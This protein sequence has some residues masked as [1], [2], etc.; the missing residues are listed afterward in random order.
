MKNTVKTKKL[1]YKMVKPSK[2]LNKVLR[3]FQRKTN[4]KPKSSPAICPAIGYGI[5]TNIYANEADDDDMEYNKHAIAVAAATAAVAEAAL[6]AANAAAE[7]VRLTNNAP[8]LVS[9]RRFYLDDFAAVKIQSAFRGYLARRALRALKGLV[10]LQALV[11]GHFVRKQSA[12]MLR[13]LQAMVRVQARAR[14]NRVLHVDSSTCSPSKDSSRRH[15]KL[16]HSSLLQR[17]GSSSSI[18]DSTTNWLDNWQVDAGSSITDTSMSKTRGI[19]DEKNDKIL[20]VDSSKPDSKHKT[21]NPKRLRHISAYDYYTHSFGASDYFASNRQNPIPEDSA[22]LTSLHFT[23]E[24]RTESM[25]ISP[26]TPSRRYL[27]GHSTFAS[28]S[29]MANT[30]SSRAKTRSQS[31]PRQRGDGNERLGSIKRSLHAFWESKTSKQIW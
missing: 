20:E 30:Q 1:H 31:V 26:K 15:Q 12:D 23:G 21:L 18:R 25:R 10:K 27:N 13:R 22:S 28:P 7:V 11:R 2:W 9:R 5:E 29:Y 8:G 3:H 16:E 14:S 4:P 17:R 6:A 24:S 19:D